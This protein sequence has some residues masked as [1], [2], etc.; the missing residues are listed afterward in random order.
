MTCCAATRCFEPVRR[1]QIFCRDHWFS[2][3]YRLR[4]SIGQSWRARQ[5]GVYRDSVRAA[6]D[7]IEERSGLYKHPL[8]RIPLGHGGQEDGARFPDASSSEPMVAI[9]VMGVAS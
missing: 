4:R 5:V 1:G 8:D 9:P 7:L 2:L 6:I 3:P